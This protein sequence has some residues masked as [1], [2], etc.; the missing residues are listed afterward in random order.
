M[1]SYKITVENKKKKNNLLD[2][3]KKFSDEKSLINSERK[4]KIKK[5]LLKVSLVLLVLIS[6]LG[7][8]GY[9][10]IYIPAMEVKNQAYILMNEAKLAKL[11]FDNQDLVGV[12]NQL[13]VIEN[14]LD[15]F[16]SKYDYF[17]FAEKIPVAKGYYT[18]GIYVIEA[19]RLSLPLGEKLLDAATPI[20]DVFGFTTSDGEH[21]EVGGQ[22]KIETIVRNLPDISKVLEDSDSLVEE[23]LETLAKIDSRY[24]P[25]RVGDV[26]LRESFEDIEDVLNNGKLLFGDIQEVLRL[27]PSMMGVYE[28]Q[29][30]LILFQNDMEVRPTGGFITAFGYAEIENGVL[31]EVESQDIYLLDQSI[32]VREKAPIEISEYLGVN[33]WFIRDSNIHADL[34]TTS[35]RFEE[36]YQKQRSPRDYDGVLYIDTALVKSLVSTVEPIL[37]EKHN[38]TITSENVVIELERYSEKILLGTDDRKGFIEDLMKELVSRIMEAQRDEW[39]N[40]VSVVWESLESKSLQFYFHN[41]DAQRLASRYKFTGEIQ[42]NVEG[43]YI[44]IVE[45]NMGGLKANMYVESEVYHNIDV[46]EDGTVVKNIKIKWENPEPSD[47]WLNG[48]YRNWL[49]VY[50]PKGSKLIEGDLNLR[51]VNESWNEKHYGKTIFDTFVVVPVATG[52][53][54]HDENKGD[55][56]PG[57]LEVEF[58]YELPFKV[59]RDNPYQYYIQKQPGRYNETQYINVN[60]N[61]ERIVL[62]KDIEMELDY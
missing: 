15:T 55:C 51:E 14:E 56:I 54:F 35:E 3:E 45:S 13:V 40:L 43:D 18:N 1:K 2:F 22:E 12:Q 36:L 19:A 52:C 10:I 38:E 25:T 28:K 42:E 44:Y 4:E 60:G 48:P 61:L 26:D 7:V 21:E 32:P 33:Q 8:L 39:A 29:T 30:Y 47:F 49:R 37:V 20:A 6:V 23:I 9:F 16:S 11:Y 34:V 17:S 58:S 31:G 53:S 50:V 5:V 59:Q 46:D 41:E 62:N 57:V 27:V 24:I